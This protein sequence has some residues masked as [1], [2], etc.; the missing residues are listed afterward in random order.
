[1]DGVALPGL[2]YTKTFF[3]QTLGAINQ[4]HR[5]VCKEALMKHRSPKDLKNDK[6]KGIVITGYFMLVLR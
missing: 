4:K 3:Y 2:Q 1:M 6:I 5:L